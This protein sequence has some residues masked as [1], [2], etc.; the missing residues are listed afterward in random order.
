MYSWSE[1]HVTIFPSQEKD[2]EGV[3]GHLT[4][5][6]TKEVI[7]LMPEAPFGYRKVSILLNTIVMYFCWSSNPWLKEA[8]TESGW[9]G[10]Q[11]IIGSWKV[12]SAFDSHG[13][14]K[15]MGCITTH[16][17]NSIYDICDNCILQTNRSEQIIILHNYS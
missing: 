16:F 17:L 4:A 6:Y 3:R 7:I 11:Y 1:Y 14:D 13:I 12:L 8:S 9:E 2:S 15:L 10:P 5:F